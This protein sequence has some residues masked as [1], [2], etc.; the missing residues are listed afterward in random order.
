[1][2]TLHLALENLKK[3]DWY[4]WLNNKLGTT[5]DVEKRK[6]HPTNTKQEHEAYLK[7]YHAC[8]M[9]VVDIIKGKELEKA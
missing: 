2:N 9:D 5:K 7:G 4:N 6:K 3:T 1:M 8:H